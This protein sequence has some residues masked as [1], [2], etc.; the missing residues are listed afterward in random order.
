MFR[1]WPQG[2]ERNLVN[3]VVRVVHNVNETPGFPDAV[4]R[5][6]GLPGRENPVCKR[7]YD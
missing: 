3:E 7:H 6:I 4:F 5:K 2:Q 1:A